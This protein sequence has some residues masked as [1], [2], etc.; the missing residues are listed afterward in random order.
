[1]HVADDYYDRKVS[2][3]YDFRLIVISS[4]SWS[5][6]SLV[7]LLQN[8]S[9][10]RKPSKLHALP[11]DP[12]LY[13]GRF[14]PRACAA[15]TCPNGPKGLTR[16]S[17]SSRDLQ[18]RGNRQQVYQ[19][20]NHLNPGG[21]RRISEIWTLAVC[22]EECCVSQLDQFVVMCWVFSTSTSLL[23][24]LSRWPRGIKRGESSADT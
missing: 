21:K 2:D 6:I 24:V 14:L 13:S 20:F 15:G 9:C 11:G 18:E 1:M 16:G 8:Y 22:S 5:R 3:P 4:T 7:Y 19:V 12:S 23:I 17:Q 10:G